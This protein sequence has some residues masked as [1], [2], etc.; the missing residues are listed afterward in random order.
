MTINANANTARTPQS[1]HEAS[2]STVQSDLEIMTCAYWTVSMSYN[3]RYK[4]TTVGKAITSL[5]V[6]L[7]WQSKLPRQTTLHRVATTLQNAIIEGPTNG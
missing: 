6:V 1:T 3:G 2:T 5:R 4:P 7:E